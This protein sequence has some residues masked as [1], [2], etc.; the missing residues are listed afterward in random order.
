MNNFM[1]SKRFKS[2]LRDALSDERS[3]KGYYTRMA[4]NAPDA[5]TRRT[6]LRIAR[7]ERRHKVRLSRIQRHL[8]K[9]GKR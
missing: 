8:E 7:Q 5:R 9:K 2:Q 1:V 3:A 6:L 4:K